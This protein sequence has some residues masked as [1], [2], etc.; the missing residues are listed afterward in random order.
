[1][2]GLASDLDDAVKSSLAAKSGAPL[3]G[4]TYAM[5]ECMCVCIHLYVFVYEYIY[6]YIHICIFLYVDCGI[7][8]TAK[9]FIV[10]SGIQ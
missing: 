3:G 9:L 10:L 8:V 5:C 1:V 7:S 4:M 2:S 6:M